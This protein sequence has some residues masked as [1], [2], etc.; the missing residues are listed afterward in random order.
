MSLLQASRQRLNDSID[1]SNGPMEAGELSEMDLQSSKQRVDD[2]T[3]NDLAAQAQEAVVLS[4]QAH[5]HAGVAIKTEDTPA[6]YP[7][8]AAL[9]PLQAWNLNVSPVRIKM[10]DT[11]PQK[12]ALSSA[13][14]DKTADSPTQGADN[15]AV[16][17]VSQWLEKKVSHWSTTWKNKYTTSLVDFGF[18][19]AAILDRDLRVDN[20]EKILTEG[21][22]MKRGHALSL[23]H[24]LEDGL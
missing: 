11:Q 23:R 15:A 7:P 17:E 12:G 22:G 14:R 8:A 2:G 4:P 21:V 18:D 3:G 1:S 20:A 16:K 13:T 5:P 10:E 24:A 19:S 6:K 9:P